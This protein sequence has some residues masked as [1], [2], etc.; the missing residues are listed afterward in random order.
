MS[1]ALALSLTL[2]PTLAAAGGDDE[3]AALERYRVAAQAKEAALVA[4]EEGYVRIEKAWTQWRTSET[5]R[6][7][8]LADAL[9]EKTAAF[10]RVLSERKAAAESKDG[11]EAKSSR[12]AELEELEGQLRSVL[13]ERGLADPALRDTLAGLAA[14]ETWGRASLDDAKAKLGQLLF[15]WLHPAGRFEVLWNDV[16]HPHADE[17]KAWRERYDEYIAAGVELDRVRHPETYLPGGAKTSRGM[18]YV[19]GGTYT[20]GPNVGFDRKKHKVTVRPFLID[21]CEVSNADYVTFLESLPSEQRLLHTPRSWELGGDGLARPPKDRLDHPVSGVT[22]RDADAYAKFVGKR[23]PTEDEWEI[24]CRGKEA[25]LFPWGF[26]YA[27]GRC[28]DAKLGLG[29]TVPV[30]RFEEGASPFK[31]LNLAGNVEEWTA[32]LEEGDTIA[33]LPSNIAAV[34][35]RGGHYLSPP[36]NVGALFRWVAPGGSS[37]EPYLGFRCA[38]DLK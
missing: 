1:L 24:A 15:P 28:D 25:Y 20:V 2:L 27:E 33:E 22:W 13:E 16:L 12:R 3:A 37:R 23:L 6:S 14:R 36:E 29:A 8:P 26:E 35:V 19:P 18:V 17:V 7:P 4:L 21:R 32:S 10:A 31:A 34:V 38:A 9:A 30:T 11:K 5:D